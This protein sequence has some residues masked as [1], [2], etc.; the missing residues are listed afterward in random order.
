MTETRPITLHLPEGDFQHIAAE[1][2][3]RGLSTE[4]V[5]RD[6]LRAAMATAGTTSPPVQ[7]AG[8]AALEDLATLT[9]DLPPVDAVQLARAIRADLEARAIP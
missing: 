9:A 6:Y 8:L 1:A 5:V 2:Q 7:A 4:R 3:R